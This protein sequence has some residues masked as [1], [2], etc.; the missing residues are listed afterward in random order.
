MNPVDEALLGAIVLLGVVL[1]VGNVWM[2]LQGRKK[3]SAN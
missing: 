2:W 3:K 1:V